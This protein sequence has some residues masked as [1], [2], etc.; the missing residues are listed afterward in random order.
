MSNGVLG[1][2]LVRTARRHRDGQC[3]G[4]AG[5]PKSRQLFQ[6][7]IA[8]FPHILPGGLEVASVPGVGHV[9]GA[10]GI[11]HQQGDFPVNVLS[12]EALEIAEVVAVHCNDVVI[13]PIVCAGHLAGG[14]AIASN[15]VLCEFAAG[16]RIDGVA[17]FLGGGGRRSNFELVGE[18]MLL[19]DMF[20]HKFSHRAAADVSVTDKEDFVHR[21]GLLG[22]EESKV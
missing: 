9:A 3:V 7:R 1:S 19:D 11:G 22:G 18:A 16:R 13:M 5:P 6:Q 14:F 8:T 17:D 20:H 2:E 10:V 12:D 15:A 4:G 21:R